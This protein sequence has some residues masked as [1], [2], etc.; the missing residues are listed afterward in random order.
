MAA[1]HIEKELSRARSPKAHDH[2]GLTEQDV[3]AGGGWHPC[4]ARVL[5][6]ASDGDYGFAVVEGNGDGA[7]FE[8]EEDGQE[9]SAGFHSSTAGEAVPVRSWAAPARERC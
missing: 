1:E 9:L 6:T 2:S 7:E 8:A 3:T 4:Y 5:A